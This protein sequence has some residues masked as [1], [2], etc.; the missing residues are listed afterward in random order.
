MKY[1]EVIGWGNNRKHLIPLNKVVDFDFN[2]EY[3]TISLTSGKTINIVENEST[4]KEMLSYHNINL[5]S[6]DEIR[7]LYEGLEQFQSELEPIYHSEG[8]LPF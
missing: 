2:D 8:D 4:I 3:T 6:E 7:T 1:V 5:V